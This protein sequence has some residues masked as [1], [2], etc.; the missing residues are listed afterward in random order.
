MALKVVFVMIV[1]ITAIIKT[2]LAFPYERSD[3][4]GSKINTPF[5][6]TGFGILSISLR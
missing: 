3:I 6:N 1:G 5:E 4:R 2:V